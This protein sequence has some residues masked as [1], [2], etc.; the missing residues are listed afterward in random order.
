MKKELA[1]Y[2]NSISG[3]SKFIED[4]KN[5]APIFYGTTA[6]QVIEKL[7]E[8]SKADKIGSFK[9]CHFVNKPRL[10][11]LKSRKYY[12]SDAQKIINA[13]INEM[14]NINKELLENG[15]R[16]PKLYGVFFVNN[17]YVEMQQKILGNPIAIIR[18]QEFFYEHDY[19]NYIRYKKLFEYVT[20]Q[21]NILVKLPQKAYDDLL[22]THLL[23]RT[24]NYRYDD[25][26]SENVLV[27][28]NGFTIIDIDYNLMSE[29]KKNI[30]PMPIG[31]TN[32]VYDFIHPFS[33]GANSGFTDEQNNVI[34]KNNIKV[35][36]KLLTAISN[37][38]LDYKSDYCGNLF[39]LMLGKNW[40]EIVSKINA[41]VKALKK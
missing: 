17:K 8:N 4:I 3:T 19:H 7:E 32:C 34:Y 31:N 29:N 15:A 5:D 13:R 37:K 41:E 28:K 18:E 25:S 33:Y 40:K 30:D 11:I 14:L 2:F 6:K 35:T 38:K 23:F 26:H 21:Q 1:D 16:I 36:T 24:Y 39:N 10:A 20:K 12:S 22:N 27:N 9:T